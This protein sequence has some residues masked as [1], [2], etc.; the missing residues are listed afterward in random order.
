M[1]KVVSVLH[2]KEDVKDLETFLRNNDL[3]DASA[4]WFAGF[5]YLEG[6]Q[7]NAI[8]Q[9]VFYGNKRLKVVC[10]KD[11]VAYY[12]HN[13]KDQFNAYLLLQAG[14]QAYIKIKRK[15]LHPTIEIVTPRDERVTLQ[16]N[17][18]KNKL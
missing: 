9:N 7:Q 17:K 10:V 3:L 1:A 12:L 14:E 16:I 2:T 11:G 15:L 18:N 6:D 13:D 4:I 8:A 5:P